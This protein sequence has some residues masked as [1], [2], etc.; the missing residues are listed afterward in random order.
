MRVA[1][2]GFTP[3]KG[4][5]HR[6]HE[7]V[8]LAADGPVGDRA[9][10]LV[11]AVTDRC[12]RT[13]E[14]PTLL[15]AGVSWDGTVLSVELPTGTVAGEPV[16]TGVVRDV[17]YWGRT[18][19][20]RVMDGPWAGALSEHLGRDV[21]LAS[22]TPG[23]VVYGAPVSLVTDAS[24]A[25]LAEVVGAPVDAAR[26]RATFQLGGDLEPHAEDGWI[27]RRLTLGTAEIEIRSL[28]PRCAVIDLDPAAGVPDLRLLKALGGYRRDQ[29]LGFGVDAVVTVPGRV[30]VGDEAALGTG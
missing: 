15:Q 1:R 2:V 10:C 29:Q 26:F 22:F 7:S 4:G 17:D 8:R 28:I 30:S 27:G 5:R 6:T 11:D 14:N 23:D 16:S 24:V 25:R 13:V 18:Q 3:L 19:Q 9:F 20:A 12:L 21:L